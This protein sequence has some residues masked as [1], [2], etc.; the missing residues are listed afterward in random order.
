MPL[1]EYECN[2]CGEQFEALVSASN[3]DEAKQCPECGSE[4]TE[5]MLSTFAVG[6]AKKPAPACASR[7]PDRSCGL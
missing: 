7:C 2:S 5:K 1:Y 4:S 6:K 3:K